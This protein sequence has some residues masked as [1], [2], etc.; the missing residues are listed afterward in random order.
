[1]DMEAAI[2]EVKFGCSSGSQVCLPDLDLTSVEQ[3]LGY[4]FSS[5]SQDRPDLSLVVPGS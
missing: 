2:W 5:P 4:A 1:M 3:S